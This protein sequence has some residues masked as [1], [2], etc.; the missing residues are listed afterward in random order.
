MG[1]LVPK[2]GGH[3]LFS[4]PCLPFPP[5]L[6][7]H[8]SSLASQGH[9]IRAYPPQHVVNKAL[10]RSVAA[11]LISSHLARAG[12][13]KDGSAGHNPGRSMAP[14]AADVQVFGVPSLIQG[15]S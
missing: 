10:T 12:D 8:R 6:G 4:T 7:S 5:A 1:T 3:S 9:H 14:K 13:H 11:N 2:E 15:G